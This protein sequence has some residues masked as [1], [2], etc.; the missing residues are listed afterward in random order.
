MGPT[1]KDWN[2]NTAW[3]VWR[4]ATISA[5]PSSVF[6]LS[7]WK[8]LVSGSWHGWLV[9]HEPNVDLTSVVC[10]CSRAALLLVFWAPLW[11]KKWSVQP[12]EVELLPVAPQTI[13][14]SHHC[15]ISMCWIPSGKQAI[16][17]DFRSLGWRCYSTV[18]TSVFNHTRLIFWLLFMNWSICDAHLYRKMKWMTK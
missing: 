5:F 16:G 7:S 4:H 1:V 9:A 17:S 14:S 15:H 13:L 11:G 18:V 8:V 6:L 12:S 3:Q 10:S 2:C